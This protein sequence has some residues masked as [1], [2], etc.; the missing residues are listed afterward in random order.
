MAPLL[1]FRVGASSSFRACLLSSREKETLCY[2]TILQWEKQRSSCLHHKM[3]TSTIINSDPELL[4]GVL[5]NDITLERKNTDK[6][7]KE[8]IYK[9]YVGVGGFFLS[10]RSEKHRMEVR[11]AAAKLQIKY[12]HDM[13]WIV[14]T[15]EAKKDSSQFPCY[16]RSLRL[17]FSLSLLLW[18]TLHEHNTSCQS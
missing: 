12:H 16:S 4:I 17:Y 7:S 11:Q 5:V 6:W 10:I 15:R 2:H 8:C 14:K 18:V 1:R 13:W 9:T 3:I